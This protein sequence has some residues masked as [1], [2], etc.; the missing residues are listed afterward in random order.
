M[1]PYYQGKSKVIRERPP[2]K[3]KLLHFIFY[4]L[5]FAF[6][7]FHRR[8]PSG[9]LK[10]PGRPG[11][12]FLLRNFETYFFFLAAFLAAFFFGAAFFLA[13]FFFVAILFEFNV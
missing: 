5:D 1:R 7:E 8:F 3:H 9:K 12:L 2:A 6:T 11:L 13:A 4:I 10:S